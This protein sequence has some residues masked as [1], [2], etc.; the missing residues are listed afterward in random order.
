M[1]YDKAVSKCQKD[2][3]D[4]LEK[5]M[6]SKLSSL[7]EN[8]YYWIKSGPKGCNVLHLTTTVGD[9][10]KIVISRR[11]CRF[12]VPVLCVG[13]AKWTEWES[14]E[15]CSEECGFGEQ[16]R[17]RKC[18]TGAVIGRTGCSGLEMETSPVL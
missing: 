6:I 7:R 1:T 3:H 13:P 8:K 14:W 18:P 16:S 15:K 2:G 12:Y 5:S 9:L 4:I 10:T 17:Q 11:D